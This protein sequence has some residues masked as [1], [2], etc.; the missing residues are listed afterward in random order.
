MPDMKL[1]YLI[2]NVGNGNKVLTDSIEF[3]Q[4]GQ[5][6]P[7]DTG[8]DVAKN[9]AAPT[10]VPVEILMVGL[11]NH[12]TRP[13]L[14]I[15][16]QTELHVYRAF[17]Y[18][19]G[20]HL[21]IRFRKINHDM[22]SARNT[23][24]PIKME[25][26]VQRDDEHFRRIRYFENV[27][28][29]NGVLICG[30]R[31]YFCIL[32]A[33]GEL[34]CHRFFGE[35]AMQSFAPF[36]NVN[37]PNGLIYFDQQNELQIAVFPHYLTYDSYWPVRKVPLRCTPVF[38]AYHKESKVYCLVTDTD[39]PSNKYYRFN[40][41]DKE[42]TEE[43][44]GERFLYPNVSKFQVVLVSPV[45]WEVVPK[46]S[47]ELEEWE[48]V[49]AFKNVHLAYEGTRSGFKEYICVGT[50]YN[51]SEDIT[52]RGRVRPRIEFLFYYFSIRF[53]SLDSYL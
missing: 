39:E 22:I 5:Q 16:T 52:S 36:N 26:F 18:A 53:F 51:Y 49:I 50:N 27:S 41:E 45:S 17:R 31:P 21:K 46:T 12:G 19:R 38:L 24:V 11:G 25:N 9:S 48:H 33:R 34:R 30:D 4:L 3:V 8:A 6:N 28:G 35:T 44:K 47:I 15:R 29:H 13:T 32:T 14:F 43:K 37:C 20:K 7:A 42:L 10:T 23:S 1:V 40:G 2:T